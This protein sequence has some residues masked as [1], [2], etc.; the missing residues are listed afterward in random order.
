MH[1]GWLI[2]QNKWTNGLQ[3]KYL[4]ENTNRENILDQ[5]FSGDRDTHLFSTVLYCVF[6]FVY[7]CPVSC[8]PKCCHFL[9]MV[10][11]WLRL[12]F[13]LA[14]ILPDWK[15]CTPTNIM[16][17]SV[18]SLYVDTYVQP[19]KILHLSWINK[20]YKIYPCNDIDRWLTFGSIFTSQV[21][22]ID[23]EYTIK[24]DWKTF[25]SGRK[26]KV[27]IYKYQTLYG[28]PTKSHGKRWYLISNSMEGQYEI[29]NKNTLL[30]VPVNGIVL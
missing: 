6:C 1:S 17:L 7:L 8:V 5:C 11:S 16:Y 25:C 28:W 30:H 21:N 27:S 3:V 26:A 10:H 9:W 22:K 24:T 18:P 13:S 19:Y 20:M 23:P 29:R 12:R 2:S 14:F 15:H 4:L